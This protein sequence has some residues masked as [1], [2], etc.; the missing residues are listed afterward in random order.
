MPAPVN[1]ASWAPPRRPPELA[2]GP[3]VRRRGLD[4]WGDLG[5]APY[6]TGVTLATASSVP[7]SAKDR[8]LRLMSGSASRALA[9]AV[10]VL[11]V[12]GSGGGRAA[13]QRSRRN[14]ALD[15]D[16]QGAREAAAGQRP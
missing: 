9:T 10:S 1:S 8:A 15:S 7:S 11:S 14:A 4:R 12:F 3:G 5:V 6:R 13:I 2:E 16:G